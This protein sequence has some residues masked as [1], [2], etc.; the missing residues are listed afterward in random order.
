MKIL[1]IFLSIL[2]FFLSVNIHSQDG[3]FWLNPLPQGNSYN[4]ISMTSNNTIYV[5]AS[6]GTLLKSTDNG[7]N[8]VMM[9]NNEN[10]GSLTFINDLIGFSAGTNGILKT[11][12]GGNNW[13]YIPAPVDYVY[14]FS[15]SP[16]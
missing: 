4:G 11:I 6:G 3:W 12:N 7:N 13:R 2:F 8:F 10:G 1:H 5:S 9:S 14:N 15:N 16:T